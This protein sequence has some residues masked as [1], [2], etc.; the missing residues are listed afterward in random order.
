MRE[1]DLAYSQLASGVVAQWSPVTAS[2][3]VSHV[4]NA[5]IQEYACGK[6]YVPDLTSDQSRILKYSLAKLTKSGCIYIFNKDE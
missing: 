4:G 5:C 3:A 2:S 1:I 6:H